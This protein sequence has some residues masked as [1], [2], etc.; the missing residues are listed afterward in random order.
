[1]DLEYKGVADK[2]CNVAIKGGG[3]LDK[4][5]AGIK[6]DIPFVCL[7]CLTSYYVARHSSFR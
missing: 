6:A 1:L 2:N 7:T 4:G 3:G 5:N